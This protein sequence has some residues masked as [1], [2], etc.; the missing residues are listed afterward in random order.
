MICS[1]LACAPSSK[2]PPLPS[3]PSFWK[4][5]ALSTTIARWSF[6][7]SWILIL[8]ELRKLL[9][10]FMFILSI[11]LPHSPIPDVPFPALWS[12]LIRVAGDDFRSSLQPSWSP[13][14]FITSNWWRSYFSSFLNGTRYQSGSFSWIN[15]GS[16]CHCM[17]DFFIFSL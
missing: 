2:E 15:V 11:T 16:N 13:S 12:T 1:S 5:V 7:R 6:L 4:W 8:K 9:P 3:T 10:S 17:C 14:I